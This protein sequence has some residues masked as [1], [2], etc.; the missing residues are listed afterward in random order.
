MVT[1]TQ[2]CRCLIA[3][4]AGAALT[5]LAAGSLFTRPTA[6]ETTHEA[7]ASDALR[8]A[9]TL[10]ATSALSA[11]NVLAQMTAAD[12]TLRFDIAEDGTRFVWGRPVFE[13]SLTAHGSSYISQG[14]IYPEGTLSD[15]VDGVNADGSPAFLE[16]VLG[17]WSCNGWYI[18][19]GTHATEGPW[20]ISTQLYQF[21]S[22][23]GAATLIS[24]D[25][26]LPQTGGAI[27]RAITGGAG[28]FANVRGQLADTN[29]GFN[30]AEGSNA[31]DLVAF[32]S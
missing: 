15:K 25:Y 31:R 2:S 26:V 10:D 4:V 17:Q 5:S 30:E 16:K 20:V 1:H 23:W 11:Q 21:G 22:E 12:G 9:S 6:A 27:E 29:L 19:D 24:E 3:V 14:Y 28:P 13:D 8:A 7:I 32:A 18:G